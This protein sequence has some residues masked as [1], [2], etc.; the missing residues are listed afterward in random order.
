MHDL[1]QLINFT[2]KE[3]IT[4]DLLSSPLIF[5]RLVP[6]DDS[7]TFFIDTIQESREPKSSSLL[8]S[9]LDVL[10]LLIWIRILLFSLEYEPESSPT[11]SAIQWSEWHWLMHYDVVVEFS[12]FLNLFN[13]CV[14]KLNSLIWDCMT[15]NLTLIDALWGR[16]RMKFDC[17]LEFLN[18]LLMEYFIILEFYILPTFL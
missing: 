2:V 4:F 15:E 9:P 11:N 14:N 10:A 1:L 6:S 12:T 17:I 3:S 5:P 13:Q 7:I 16:C 18:I 8:K